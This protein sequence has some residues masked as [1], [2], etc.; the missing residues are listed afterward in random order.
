MGVAKRRR[1]VCIIWLIKRNIYTCVY[2]CILYTS[3]RTCM[4]FNYMSIILILF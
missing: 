1:D 3:T 4:T 2:V